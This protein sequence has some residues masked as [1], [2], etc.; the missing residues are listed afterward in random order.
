MTEHAPAERAHVA[1]EKV[2]EPVP[3]WL[4]VTVPVGEKPETVAVHLEV[5]S[6]G[7]EDV[8]HETAVAVVAL[9]TVAP[10]VPELPRLSVSPA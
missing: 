10:V 8:V 5:A 1:V 7:K 9:L 3:P 4:Q 2:T 6:T